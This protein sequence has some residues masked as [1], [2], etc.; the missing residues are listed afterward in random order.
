MN[1]P[2]ITTTQPC[3]KSRN[4]STALQAAEKS[5]F[6]VI[7]NE[8]RNPSFAIAEQKRDSSSLRSSE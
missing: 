4:M 7:P 3:R 6:G 8:V 1:E 5:R 2:D